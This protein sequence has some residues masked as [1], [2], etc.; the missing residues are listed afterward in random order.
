MDRDA[1][2]HLQDAKGLE[3][4]GRAAASLVRFVQR[5]E[6]DEATL[7]TLSEVG[8]VA[9]WDKI[10]AGAAM[11]EFTP[12]ESGLVKLYDRLRWPPTHTNL[13]ALGVCVCV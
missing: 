4:P 6:N 3:G 2:R 13:P 9:A 12:D 7:D 5:S 1:T 10:K 8:L 11:G